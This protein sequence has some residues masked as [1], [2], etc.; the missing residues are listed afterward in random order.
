MYEVCLPTPPHRHH[1]ITATVAEAK[2]ATVSPVRR[3]SSFRVKS[4][5]TSDNRPITSVLPLASTVKNRM[6]KLLRRTNSTRATTTGPNSSSTGALVGG[7]MVISNKRYSMAECRRPPTNAA[8]EPP[9]S[10]AVLAEPFPMALG[11]VAPLTGSAAQAKT[12]TTESSF[13]IPLKTSGANKPSAVSNKEK[14]IRIKEGERVQRLRMHSEARR[15][16]RQQQQQQ[17]QQQQQQQKVS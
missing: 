3:P 14:L 8:V 12:S 1:N 6:L 16:S 17:R 13:V 11:T 2:T 15:H 10:R 7:D 5:S 9:S 4:T